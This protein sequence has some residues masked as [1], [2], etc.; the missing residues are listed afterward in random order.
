MNWLIWSNQ[1]GMWWRPE[2]RGYTQVIEE[3]GRYEYQRAKEIVAQATVGHRLMTTRTN[4]RTGE[5][6]ESFDEVMVLAPESSA[7]I[8]EA[9]ESSD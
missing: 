4:P 8:V 3:A 6:Y 5:R 2:E 1:H 7:G 9:G